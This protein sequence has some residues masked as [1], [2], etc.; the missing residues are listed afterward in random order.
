LRKK[1]GGAPD[2]PEG[3]SRVISILLYGRNDSHGYNLHKRAAISLNALA[4]VLQDPNDEILF[5]DYNTPDDLVTFPEAIA[6]TLTPAC[7]KLLRILRIRPEIHHRLFKSKTDLPALEPISRNAALRRSNPANSWILCT[8]TDMIFAPRAPRKSLNDV[9]AELAPGF[10]ELPRYEMPDL[11]WESLD[12]L[13][14]KGNIAKARDWGTRFHIN[15]LVLRGKE[16]LFDAP[17]DF[18]LFPRNVAFEISGFDESQ[19]LGWHLDAN[20]A[21]RLYLY[22]GETKSAQDVLEGWHCNHTRSATLVHRPGRRTNDISEV[23]QEVVRPDLPLQKDSW[24]LPEETLEETHLD[25][26]GKSLLAAKLEAL[27]PQAPTQVYEAPFVGA[28]DVPC[29]IPHMQAYLADLLFTLPRRF[30]VGYLGEDP[31]L[32]EGFRHVWQGLEFTG[33]L[34]R[35]NRKDSLED[36]AGKCDFFVAAYTPVIEEEMLERRASNKRLLAVLEHLFRLERTRLADSTLSPR[37]FMVLNGAQPDVAGLMAYYT[38]AQENPAGTRLRH[39]YVTTA[40]N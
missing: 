36:A 7:K 5:V 19:L 24:G 32:F 23:F 40:K 33:A 17:G 1:N 38:N 31:D 15:E 37:K 30:S 13:D 26:A 20:I 4:E 8:N 18:Q 27:L 22:F 6:D 29:P 14:P 12:R 3:R 21:K 16:I 10:Y 2:N 28:D 9:V 25:P 34:H 39:G 11:L 35:L